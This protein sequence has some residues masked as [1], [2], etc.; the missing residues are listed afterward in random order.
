M[1]YLLDSFGISM[2]NIIW[3]FND[4]FHNKWDNTNKDNKNICLSIHKDRVGFFVVSRKNNLYV[5]Y[6]YWNISDKVIYS[7]KE[8]YSFIN[9]NIKINIKWK[10]WKYLFI[11]SNKVLE[12]SDFL[13][14]VPNYYIKWEY[15]YGPY[16]DNLLSYFAYLKLN[17]KPYLYQAIDEESKLI[18]S[19][20]PY[21]Y[22]YYLVLDVIWQD[23]LKEKIDLDKIYNIT[24]TKFSKNLKQI[25]DKN[26][27]NISLDLNFKLEIDIVKDESKNF[28]LCP[29][30]D[31]HS[32][33][34][35][36]KISTIGKYIDTINLIIKNKIWK[37]Y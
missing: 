34:S 15:L 35:Y 33:N 17:T 10:N 29:V 26:V 21:W 8:L 11:N 31:G 6:I 13:M 25:D 5:L 28:L 4:L 22:D 20:I 3:I 23:Y 16:L 37:K 19:K 32:P 18:Y 9:W 24:N 12:L 7:L 1:N 36:V 14:F 30:V 27:K 2:N